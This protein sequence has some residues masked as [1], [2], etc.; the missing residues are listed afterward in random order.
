ME[1]YVI[2]IHHLYRIHNKVYKKG[3]IWVNHLNPKKLKK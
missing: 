3:N 2:T 1:I